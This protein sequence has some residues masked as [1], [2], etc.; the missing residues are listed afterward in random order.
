MT[1]DLSALSS[2][3]DER[4]ARRRRGAGAAVPGRARRSGSRCTPSTC[5]ADR[6][7]ADLVAAVAAEA[8]A[9][10]DR[11]RPTASPTWPE[12]FGLR[13][14]LGRR[15]CTAGCATSWSAS[16]SRTCGSTSRTAT[17]TAATTRRTPAV[18]AAADGL[19]RAI[20]GGG[21]HRRSRGIRFKSFEAPT[22]Q[23]GLRT[24]G[25]VRGGGDAGRPAAGRV[26]GDAAQGD[27]GRAGR[28]DGAR[29]RAVEPA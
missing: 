18:D 26:R 27:L 17:A 19:L 23:R 24:L 8:L 1:V 16:R 2:T 5:P 10:L 6:Y 15:T 7:D 3:L 9:V 20:D 4:L 25:A 13:P 12:A 14:D 22:R 11:A 29:V 28:G 21:R